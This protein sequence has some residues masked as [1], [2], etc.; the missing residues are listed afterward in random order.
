MRLLV[1]SWPPDLRTAAPNGTAQVFSHT[2]TAAALP[3]FSTAPISSMSDS[4]L[5][6]SRGR[7][8]S[9]RASEALRSSKTASISSLRVR[10]FV[11]HARRHAATRANTSP[12]MIARSVTVIVALWWAAI[13]VGYWR[14]MCIRSSASGSWMS[15]PLTSTVTLWM[16]PVNLKGLA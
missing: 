7:P 5:I 9:S 1:T 8:V 14:A 11:C 16:V 15:S 3:G 6:C 12:A 13:A 10:S 2:S 4:K